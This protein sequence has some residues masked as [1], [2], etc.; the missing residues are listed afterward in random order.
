LIGFS[1]IVLN[2]EFD[3]IFFVG[4]LNAAGIIDFSH[5]HLRRVFAGCA[6]GRNITRQFGDDADFDLGRIL[7]AA[8]AET[9]RKNHQKNN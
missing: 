3:F 4:Q 5:G 7:F 6:Y 2:D 1:G 8:T 9:E